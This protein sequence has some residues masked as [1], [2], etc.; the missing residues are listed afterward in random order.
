MSAAVLLPQQ[1]RPEEEIDTYKIGFLLNEAIEK[2][3]FLSKISKKEDNSSEL[4]GFEIRKLLK[5]QARLEKKY[6]GLI[7]E[8]SNLKGIANRD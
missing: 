3:E 7:K 6:A 8:R 4:A 5:E 2:I 1:L